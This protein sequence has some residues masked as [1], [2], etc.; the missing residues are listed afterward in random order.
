MEKNTKL[1][2]FLAKVN[3]VDPVTRKVLQENVMMKIEESQSIEQLNAKLAELNV[4]N[5]LEL[6]EWIS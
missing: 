5:R 3:I 2:G 6:V 4:P 1:N